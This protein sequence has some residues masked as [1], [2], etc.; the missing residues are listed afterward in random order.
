MGQEHLWR[1]MSEDSPAPSPPL[2]KLRSHAR[3]ALAADVDSLKL[4]RR[5]LYLLL[6]GMSGLILALPVVLILRHRTAAPP[7]PPPVE[8]PK[9]AAS[10]KPRKAPPKTYADR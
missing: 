2:P 9:P 3:K 8:P 5:K 6:G 4:R 1:S 10:A 7:P